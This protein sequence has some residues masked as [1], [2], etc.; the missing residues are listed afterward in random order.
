MTKSNTLTSIA[1][2][3]VKRS[4]NKLDVL[5]LLMLAGLSY[6]IY[7]RSSVGINYTWR[8]Q[9]AFSLLFTPRADG[10]LPYFFQG[11]I[12]TLRL[13]IWGMVLAL[14][15]GTALGVARHSKI[16][17]FAVPANMFVQL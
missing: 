17:L 9:E 4:T 2:P 16:T 12:S 10:S 13:S 6:W 15:L 3:V 14:S 1:P 5:L 7:D 8:W 11:L